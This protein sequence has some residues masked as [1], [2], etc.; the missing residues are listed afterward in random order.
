MELK[1]VCALEKILPDAEIRHEQKRGIKLSG[2][3]FAFQVCLRT[4][5]Q[6]VLRCKLDYE[7]DLPL[8][9]YREEYVSGLFTC[10]LG[11]DGYIL[12]EKAT[13]FPDALIPYAGE[14]FSLAPGV[15]SVFWVELCASAN[16]LPN[17]YKIRFTARNTQ[18]PEDCACAEYSV[19]V[20][21]GEL[22]END[23]LVTKWIHSDCIAQSAHTRPFTQ[24]FYR[25][26]RSAIWLAV[27]SGQN[28]AYLP[29]F[30]PPLDTAVGGERFTVQ[31]VDVYEK[32]GEYRF[33]FENLD[34]LVRICRE[35]GVRY[36][37]TSHLFTQWGARF[38]PKVLVRKEN[39]KTEKRFGWKTSSESAEYTSFLAAFLPALSM[40]LN[41]LGIREYTYLHLS[42]EPPVEDLA[43]YMRLHAFVKQYS[44]GMK[45]M[46]AFSEYGFAEQGAPDF[47]TVIEGEEDEFIRHGKDFA[48]YY[49]CITDKNNHPNI[50]LNMPLLRVRV[51]GVILYLQRAKGFLHWGYNFYNSAL[52]LRRIDPFRTTDGDG[53]LPAGD[54]FCVYPDGHGGV[55]SSIRQ[56]TFAQAMQDYRLLKSCE[57]IIGRDATLQIL[58]KYGF[59]NGYDYSH[60][61]NDYERLREELLHIVAD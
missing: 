49:S 41:E 29:L 10:N 60:D 34:E 21:G 44:G 31:A 4:E 15:N 38:C 35:E 48:L 11:H 42:D 14:E 20:L 59:A 54:P 9:V 17:E 56:E 26:F 47:P 28:T 55:Y 19:R 36:F 52:S 43:R 32:N 5:E 61:E 25:A 12:D 8:C 22:A 1:T 7:S 58:Q 13:V 27:Q 37:E 57:G 53:T 33:S 2:E 50:F 40:H 23:L 6:A 16:V 3:R 30:T 24:K 45:T 46:D 18:K 51:L 39:G